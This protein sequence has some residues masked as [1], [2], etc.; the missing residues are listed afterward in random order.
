MTII[1][2]FDYHERMASGWGEPAH[3]KPARSKVKHFIR[4]V[5]HCLPACIIVHGIME[6]L[7]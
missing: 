7:L 2:D 6:V 3:V 4:E 5:V 1:E